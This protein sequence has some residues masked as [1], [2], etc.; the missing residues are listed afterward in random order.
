[1]CHTLCVC[2]DRYQDQRKDRDH[3]E[4]DLFDVCHCIQGMFDAGDRHSCSTRGT[5]RIR[6]A[7]GGGM[8]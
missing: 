7:P 8:N 6:D 5:I 2:I 3:D 1:M 4:K